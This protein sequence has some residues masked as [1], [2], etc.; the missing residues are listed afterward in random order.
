MYARFVASPPTHRALALPGP[1]ARVVVVADTHSRPHP[2][3]HDLI[4]AEAP[5][6]ILH[7]GDVGD[8]QVL[9]GGG[10]DELHV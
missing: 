4:R 8:A 5:A 1:G 2:A 9:D 3:T 10:Q 6:A 7:A